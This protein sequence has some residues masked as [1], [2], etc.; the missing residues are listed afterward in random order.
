MAP[1]G[2]KV[3]LHIGTRKSGTSYLQAALRESADVLAEQGVELVYKTR[4]GQVERQLVPLQQYAETGDPT[5]AEAAMSR[6]VGRLRAKP[7]MRHLM[8]LEDL[9]ELPA[10]PVRLMMDALADFDVELII[11]ARHWGVT[12]PSEWQQCVKERYTGSLADFVTAIRDRTQGA[13][14]FLSRQDVPG[15][16]ARWGAGLEPSKVHVIAVPPAS[17]TEGSLAELFC[18]LIDVDPTTLAFP[19]GALNQSISVEQAELLRRVNLALGDRLPDAANGYRDGIK[20]WLTRRSLMRRST[21]GVKLPEEFLGWVTGEVA[22]QYDALVAS[23]VDIVGDPRDLVDVSSLRTGPDS[24]PEAELV[25]VAVNAL[26]DLGS[27][28]WRELGQQREKLV[29]A[30]RARAEAEARA[31]RAEQELAR[32]RSPRRRG[33]AV[34]R[35]IRSA[36]RG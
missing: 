29:E 21:G 14:Q 36:D 16:V 34:L 13:D 26:A 12:V 30:E 17:R 23:G 3:Y 2:T 20:N 15:I 10:E 8:T 6:V 35:R 31:Q 28:R 5:E 18:R 22:A 11:T 19:S 32:L 24:V 33:A 1:T 27:L 7:E 4:P 9:A 25:D